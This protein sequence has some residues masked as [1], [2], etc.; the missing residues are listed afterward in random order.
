MPNHKS[1]KKRVKISNKERLRNRGYR[2]ELR[3]SIRDLRQETNKDEATKKFR[4]VT[5][6]LDKAANYGL[7]HKK[8]ANRNK[9]RLAHFV[10][11][12]G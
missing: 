7:I 2:S 8:N 4:N 3:S 6:L 10:Q 12:L 5:I 11:Q 9:S 1:C